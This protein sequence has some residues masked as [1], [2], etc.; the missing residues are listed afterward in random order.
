MTLSRREFLRLAGLA[1]IASAGR[2]L[3]RWPALFFAHGV[4]DPWKG[5]F[6]PGAHLGRVTLA[7]TALR[8]RPSP[9]SSF[10]GWKEQD[11]VVE[12]LREVVGQGAQP[13]NHVWMETSQGYLYFPDLQ[14][15]VFRPSVPLTIL[16]DGGFW[17]QVTVPYVDSWSQPSAGAR[18]VFRLYYAS[19]Y[20]I[21]GVGTDDKGQVWYHIA[22][23]NAYTPGQGLTPI[24]AEDLAPISPQVENKKIV[25][26]LE[27][28]A[29]SAFE[30][31]VEVFH[32][33]IASGGRY[34]SGS[35]DL[36]WATTPGNYR[37]QWKRVGVHMAAGTQT[38]GYDLP[39]VGWVTFFISSNGVAI[40]STYWH[41]DY[42]V[43]KSHGCVNARPQDAQWIFRWTEPAVPYP[44]GDVHP[45]PPGGTA[46][47]VRD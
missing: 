38:V 46:I 2:P 24:T 8:S 43:P 21:N 30:E 13:Q 25:V 12:V 44:A 5:Q 1:A 19:V 47:I 17:A 4:V 10:L 34:P 16:P 3:Y 29:L 22:D 36:V 14:P 7:R 39:G 41:N 18:F 9:D 27:R 31:Q 28:Q 42:G 11:D 6:Q 20:Q 40:H 15:I 33:T 37:V 45:P 26:N 23:L 32:A 35:G